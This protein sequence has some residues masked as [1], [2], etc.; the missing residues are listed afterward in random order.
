MID[1]NLKKP[2]IQKL[3]EKHKIKFIVLFGSQVKG[4]PGEDSDFDIAIY[5]DRLNFFD[6]YSEILS[7]LAK[8]FGVFEDKIDLTDLKNANIL[9]RYEIT[10]EGKLLYGRE[11]D[12]LELKSFAFRDYIAAQSLF[13]LEYLIIK[14]KQKLFAKNLK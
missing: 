12:Y 5:T 7:D 3:A 8:I 6:K 4:I 1:F 13:N 14:K 11:L 10:S 2:E 9:L